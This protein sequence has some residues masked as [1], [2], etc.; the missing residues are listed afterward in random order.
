MGHAVN[1]AAS[2]SPFP[3]TCLTRSLV[4]LYLLQRHAIPGQLR[5]GVRVEAGVLDAHAW[6]ELW[7]N[8]VNDHKDVVTAYNPFDGL[9]QAMRFNTP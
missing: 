7:G 3:C 5:I 8:P 6:V 4:L 2:Q 9:E 1:V